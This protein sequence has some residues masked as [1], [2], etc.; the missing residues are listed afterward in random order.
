MT[1]PNQTEAPSTV[2]DIEAL[3][4]QHL[5]PLNIKIAE[6]LVEYRAAKEE[7]GNGLK[8]KQRY[9]KAA[10]ASQ[11]AAEAINLKLCAGLIQPE[12]S[13]KEAYK[14][15]AERAGNLYDNE[16]NNSIERASDVSIAAANLRASRLAR[17]IMDLRRQARSAAVGLL[18]ELIASKLKDEFRPIAIFVNL[19]AEIAE[20]GDSE[21]YNVRGDV[22]K[23]MDFALGELGKILGVAF[24]AC[25]RDMR[26]NIFLAELPDGLG[27]SLLSPLAAKKMADEIAALEAAL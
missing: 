23:P 17:D 22:F 26:S 19:V 24:S 21:H 7:V 18:S 6:C 20:R 13:S 11:A 14:L 5:D 25:D 9:G 27:Q 2:F 10:A 15:R 1:T 16:I 4:K 8:S 3:L 12:F